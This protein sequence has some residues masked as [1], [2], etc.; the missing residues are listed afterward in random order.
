MFTLFDF[1]GGILIWIMIFFL[2]IALG[3]LRKPR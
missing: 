3:E 2:S 1:V